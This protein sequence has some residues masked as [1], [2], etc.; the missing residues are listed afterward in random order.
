[1]S[2]AATKANVR[3]GTQLLLAQN[4]VRRRK[5]A[6]TSADTLDA[7]VSKPYGSAFFY[8]EDLAHTGDKDGADETGT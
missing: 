7:L 8:E 1:M 2:N 5:K 4:S 6:R 3:Y